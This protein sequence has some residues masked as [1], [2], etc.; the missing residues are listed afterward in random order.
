MR[1]AVDACLT[2]AFRDVAV[3]D[4]LAERLLA[5]LAVERPR[6]RSRRWLLAVGGLA[7]AAA[8]VLLAVWLGG[9]KGE[10]VSE[11][12][13]R[14]EA[15]QQFNVGSPQPGLSLAS[16]P[17]S[18]AAAYPFSAQVLPIR[19][20]TWRQVGDFLGC[21]AVVYDLPGPAGTRAALYVVACTNVAGIGSSPA[22]PQQVF[23][24]NGCCA[25]AWLEGGLLCVLVV[26]GDKSTYGQYL[27]LPSSP[28]A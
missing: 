19:G 12:T 17:T 18:T 27:K 8:T 1:D 25:S 7:A 14:D 15:I 20:T 4:G 3:P 6:P 2:K 13:A 5:G 28:V 10:C 9:A 22:M 23:M 24:T 21:S 16:L 11:E 26:E